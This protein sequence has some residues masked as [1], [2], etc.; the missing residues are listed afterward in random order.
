M[1]I[2]GNW[3][4]TG[5]ENVKKVLSKWRKKNKEEI[6]KFFV[7]GLNK[8]NSIYTLI[9]ATIGYNFKNRLEVYFYFFTNNIVVV[10]TN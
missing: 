8:I 7:N 6:P 4:K 9:K 5:R 10:Y 3:W 2:G 1:S